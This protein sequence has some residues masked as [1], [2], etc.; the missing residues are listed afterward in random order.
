MIFMSL[1]ARHHTWE[2]GDSPNT[3]EIFYRKG[4]NGREGKPVLPLIFADDREIRFFSAQCICQLALE[5]TFKNDYHD[6]MAMDREK[7]RL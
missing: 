7:R 2:L 6:Y 4:R 1:Q 3:S 5:S